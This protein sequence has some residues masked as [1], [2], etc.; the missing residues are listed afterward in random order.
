MDRSQGVRPQGPSTEGLP[1]FLGWFL[2]G[3]LLAPAP[4]LE[5]TRRTIG[6][7]ATRTVALASWRERVRPADIGRGSSPPRVSR[8]RWAD[9]SRS[10]ALVGRQ[11]PVIAGGSPAVPFAGPRESSRQRQQCPSDADS[12]RAPRPYWTHRT[13]RLEAAQAKPS[14]ASSGWAKCPTRRPRTYKR[15]QRVPGGLNIKW[16]TS[17]AGRN[18]MEGIRMPQKEAAWNRRG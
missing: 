10:E 5:A 1:S 6:I 3:L 7:T 18:G 11:A 17:R 13:K 12:S 4:G 16:S 15:Y 14:E 9:M 8:S 2:L